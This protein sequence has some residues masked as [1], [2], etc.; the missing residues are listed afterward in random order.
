MIKKLLMKRLLLVLMMCAT[1]WSANVWTGDPNVICVQN[2]DLADVNN[3]SS[4][5][6]YDSSGNAQHFVESSPKHVDANTADYKQGTSAGRFNDL[7][8]SGLGA[9]ISRADAALSAAWP[10]KS[11]FSGTAKFSYCAWFKPDRLPTEDAGDTL[12]YLLGKWGTSEACVG[13]YL[14]YDGAN[15]TVRF[16]KGWDNG[17][18]SE[19][20]ASTTTMVSGQWYHVGITY[21]DT[22]HGA[23]MRLWDDTAGTVSETTATHVH[24]WEPDASDEALRIGNRQIS[25]AQR[26]EFDGLMDEVVFFNDELT[27]AEIDQIRLGTYGSSSTGTSDWWYRRRHN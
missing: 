12:R 16:A 15:S 14:W 9:Y 27:S 18:N 6:W 5:W 13:V 8:Y 19:A 21:D 2:F 24:A 4:N 20:L 17:D 3:P 25:F 7:G 1:A 26:Y 11:T 22:D 23:V 10:I